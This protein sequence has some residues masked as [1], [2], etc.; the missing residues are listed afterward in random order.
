MEIRELLLKHYG[1]FE[2]HRI[3]LKPGVNVIY[4]G[5]E[6]GKT[7][8][9][10]FITAM[11]FGLSR[12]R[13]KAAKSDEYQIRQPWDAPGAFLGSMKVES[14]GQIYRI[15]RCFDHSAQQLAVTCETTMWESPQ[16]EQALEVLLGGVGEA[17]YVNT[18][19]I[20][21]SGARTGEA[22]AQEL[23]RYMI[24]SDGAPGGQ[25]DVS[26][27]LQNLRRRKKQ[28]EQQK[29]KDDEITEG[30]IAEKQAKAEALRGEIDLLRRQC[31]SVS[32]G[33]KEENRFSDRSGG[34][35]NRYAGSAPGKRGS[36]AGVPDGRLGMPD[37]R[38][39]EPGY[40]DRQM[41]GMQ[42]R[43]QEKDDEAFYRKSR[44]AIR[45]LLLITGILCLA[46]AWLLKDMKVRIE[47]GACGVFF[48]AMI[49]PVKLMFRSEEE[50]PDYREAAGWQT[51]TGYDERAMRQGGSGGAGGQS[52]QGRPADFGQPMDRRDYYLGEEIRRREEE[53]R[54]LQDE[55]EALYQSHVR[56]EGADTEIA[57]LTLAIDRICDLSSGIYAQSGRQL[58]ERASEILSE[59]TQGRYDR[60]LLD[61]TAEVRIHTPSRVLGLHQ[62][63]GGTMQQI[64]FALRMAAAEL[65]CGENRLPILLDEPFAL[66][67]DDRLE[68]AL[69]WF[70][71][72][73]RQVI[74]F[75]CQRREQEILQRIHS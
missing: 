63:S 55:L 45:V 43:V 54:K 31:G 36:R 64:Y 14:R 4:G 35:E 73:G 13:G 44:L 75:T 6:T 3:L 47:L 67:D 52:L 50:E 27:A 61:E 49:V 33:R 71:D 18:L 69:R 25:M 37:R 68:A 21:Q 46:A 8:I 72:C 51:Q 74:I 1:K 22:L 5:N 66:Y 9:H 62:V 59:L 65:L 20:P 29:K 11:L 17:A 56:I 28:V 34:A 30:R 40:T 39:A 26:R 41:Q 7:T 60:I 12:A 58:N 19:C 32:R 10:S 16:P 2:N 38:Q 70:K 24:N 23:R 42:S 15:D 48:L 57:A 53:Y